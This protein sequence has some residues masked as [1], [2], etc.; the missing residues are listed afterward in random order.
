MKYVVQSASELVE[1]IPRMLK[2]A[3]LLSSQEADDL[4][5]EACINLL[6]S[7][8]AY[9]TTKYVARVVHSQYTHFVRSQ[10]KHRKIIQE[11]YDLRRAG[12]TVGEMWAVQ[13]LPSSWP[14][15]LVEAQLARRRK[16]GSVE[17]RKRKKSEYRKQWRANRRVRGLK[18]V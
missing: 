1:Y 18:V 14:D 17:E 3:R 5:Q 6:E 4:L 8:P 12:L 11:L 13:E 9:F 10:I 16:A 15:R 7:P 2:Y